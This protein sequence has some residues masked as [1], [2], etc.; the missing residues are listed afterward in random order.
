M[1]YRIGKKIVKYPCK[2]GI[3]EVEDQD[4]DVKDAVNECK[5]F[6]EFLDFIKKFNDYEIGDYRALSES[7]IIELRKE[8]NEKY[9]AN[10]IE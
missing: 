8:F 3:I 6:D 2:E 9:R 5:E 1:K 10:I 7:E 4:C